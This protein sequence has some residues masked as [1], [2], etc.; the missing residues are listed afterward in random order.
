MHSN[1]F[2]SFNESRQYR[3]QCPK[4]SG[5]CKAVC[6]L[7]LSVWAHNAF[8]HI[9]QMHDTMSCGVI[10]GTKLHKWSLFYI[11][12]CITSLIFHLS[13]S[14]ASQIQSSPVGK[15]AAA[16]STVHGDGARWMSAFAIQSITWLC[17]HH[18][19]SVWFDG[20]NLQLCSIIQLMFW[21]FRFADRTKG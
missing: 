21:G 15:N 14:C 16:I 4:L 11:P 20:L 7:T 3:H 8:S 12:L 19:R 13:L 1:E 2:T 17:G 9:L 18:N 5:C 6:F 10:M